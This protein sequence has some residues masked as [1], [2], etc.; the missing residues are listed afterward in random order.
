M[1]KLLKLF[2]VFALVASFT[3]CN[4]EPAPEIFTNFATLESANP[5]SLTFSVQE[6]PDS[7][8]VLITAD[9]KF[10]ISKLEIGGRYVIYYAY[11]DNVPSANRKVDLYYGITGTFGSK[12]S[13]ADN[14]Q[15]TELFNNNYNTLYIACAGDWLNLQFAA[16]MWNQSTV[17]LYVD[18]ETLDDEY[19]QVYFCVNEVTPNDFNQAY[20]YASFNVSSLLSLPSAKGFIVNYY[21]GGRA[22]TLQV[23]NK[24]Y[25]LSTAQ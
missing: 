14:E 7:E 17:E 8:P 6:S 5:A 21:T 1:K 16:S 13:K 22:K 11:V 18:E 19:P 2:S 3:A 23:E 12:M 15:V 9:V 4:N 10:D 20:F 24:R 25:E